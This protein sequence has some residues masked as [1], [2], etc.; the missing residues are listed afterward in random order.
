MPPIR[1]LKAESVRLAALFATL[2]LAMSGTLALVVLWMVDGAQR[3]ALLAAADADIAAVESGYR[4]EGVPEAVEVVR[5]LLGASKYAHGRAPNAYLCLLDRA[6]GPLA[7]NLPLPAVALGV[8]ELDGA[9]GRIIGRGVEVAPGLLLFV[10]R[11]ASGLA[12]TR[13]RIL[14]AFAWIIAGALLCAGVAGV[15]FGVRFMRRVDAMTR[16]CEAIVAGR[17]EERIALRGDGAEL[18]RLAVAVNAMLARIDALMGD[19]RQVSS[20]VA[21]DLRTPLTRLRNRLEAAHQAPAAPQEQAAVLSAAIDDVDRILAMF[22]AVLR[23]SQIEA[24]GG[25]RAFASLELQPLLARLVEVYRP[26]AEDLG[27]GLVGEFALPGTVRGDA[28]LLTQ[29]F[30]NLLENA[31][32]HTPPGTQIRVGLRAAAGTIEAWVSDD[33]PG[34]PPEEHANVLKRFYRLSGSRTAAGHGLGLALVAAIAGLHHARLTLQDAS[35][36]LRVSVR[37]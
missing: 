36:G 22:A 37:F 33:G 14:R 4:E 24:G 27:Q 12:V 6:H 3:A 1:L 35:P 31:I 21:H 34:I 29:L 20:D 11:D 5:Q 8:A 2:F 13:D 7:G 18:D 23:I 19:L 15:Y 16:T 30:S 32:R 28:E 25:G 9:H 26:V 10:G 17:L